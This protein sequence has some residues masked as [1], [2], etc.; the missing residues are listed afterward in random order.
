VIE[1]GTEGMT[2]LK[3][4][5]KKHGEGVD[6]VCVAQDRDRWVMVVNMAISV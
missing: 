1:T 3:W 6:C 4:T 2:I 5:L